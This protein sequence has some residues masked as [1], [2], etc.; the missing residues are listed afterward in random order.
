MVRE[1]VVMNPFHIY[2][3]TSVHFGEGQLQE[4]PNIIKRYMGTKVQLVT[5]QGLVKAGVIERVAAQLN[6]A[7]FQVDVYDGVEPDPGIDTVDRVVEA[8]NEA[9]SD[10]LLAVGGGSS[11]DAAKGARLI[12]SQ[13]GNIRDYSGINA[14]PIR[15]ASNIPVIAMPTTAGTGSEVTFFGVYSDWENNVKVTVTSPFLAPNAAVVDPS[16]TYSVPPHVTAAS[17]IDVLAHAVEAYLSR[18][19]SP[20]SETLALRA[21]ELVGANLRKA[22]F[23]GEDRMAR[24]Y[25]SE[26]S[27]LAG[28]AFNHSFLGLTHAIAAAISGHA[29]V[30]HGIAIGLMLPAVM[31][32]NLPVDADKFLRIGQALSGSPVYNPDETVELVQTLTRDIGIPQRLSD[33]G[34]T[35]DML[36][37]IARQTLESVQLRFNPRPATERDVFEIVNAMF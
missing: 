3:P 6:T 10:L 12:I 22:V 27:L 5:D 19:S 13:G 35:K 36:E 8:F 2:I 1:M 14:K 17:G 26:A 11:I 15:E 37:G 16:L 31:N 28:I 25:M 29:H 34:V 24:N 7:G 9:E 4:L 21:I 23:Y 18:A 20:F 33:V 32:Y 30:P